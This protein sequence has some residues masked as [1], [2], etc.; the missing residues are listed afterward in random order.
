MLIWRTAL[1][2]RRREG[3][4][5]SKDE[6]QLTGIINSARAGID[7]SVRGFCRRASVAHHCIVV[8]V[9]LWSCRG[10]PCRR[11]SSYLHPGVIDLKVENT[12]LRRQVTST[13]GAA[14]VREPC[15]GHCADTGCCR[16]AVEHQR[17]CVAVD[18]VSRRTLSPRRRHG[19]WK[20][21]PL[22]LVKKTRKP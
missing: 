8:M 16:M 3:R 20:A 10:V 1:S 2:Y 4:T 6:K 12:L 22:P 13:S 11:Q 19:R 17:L 15:F 18:V 5:T 7:R 21:S 9:V 14:K